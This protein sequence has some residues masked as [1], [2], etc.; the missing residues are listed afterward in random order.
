[1]M[2]YALQRHSG[3]HLIIIYVLQGHYKDLLPQY[4][5]M[6]RQEGVTVLITSTLSLLIC[7]ENLS[8]VHTCAMVLWV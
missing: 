7:T 1:M 3:E 4:I 5:N 8:F 6:K 2:F